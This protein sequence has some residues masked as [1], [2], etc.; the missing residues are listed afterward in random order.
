V[1][2]ANRGIQI[3]PYTNPA[4][5]QGVVESNS[6]TA[7]K[8]PLYFNYSENAN[9]NW[10]FRNN[11]LTGIASLTGSPVDYFAGI[12]VE[13]F[14]SGTVLFEKNQVYTGTTN[15]TAI[16]QYYER[17]TI[18]SGTR[19]A[20]PN[21][22]GSITGPAAGQIV[23]LVDYIPWCANAACTELAGPVHNVTQ[24]TWFATIQGAIGATSTSA[25]DVIEVSAGIYPEAV[26]VNKSVTITGKGEIETFTDPITVG[27][28]QAP[29]TWYTDRYAPGVFENSTF[30]GESVL[31]HGIRAV[32]LQPTA[33]YNTQ[34]RKY[35]IGLTG[36]TQLVS[37]DMFVGER[38]GYRDP[39][40]RSLGNWFR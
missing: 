4:T 19:S 11:V 29:E 9:S 18:M 35:D 15:A 38:L 31:L 16:Y 10:V 32:D 37:I 13:T 20:S 27:A 39:L 8:S 40:F 6:F 2:S 5:T 7:Y 36:P 24:D 34:G 14:Y 23:G 33:F 28:T 22:W 25:G 17:G 12:T 30:L 26:N 21:W 3:Q 1:D